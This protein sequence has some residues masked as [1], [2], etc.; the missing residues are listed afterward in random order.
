MDSV[1]GVTDHYPAVY[2]FWH[3]VPEPDEIR[4]QVRNMYE[5]GI[6]TFLIQARLAFP[7]EAYLGEGYFQAYRLAVQEAR[8]RGMKAG[9]YDEYNWCSGHAGGRT[10]ESNDQAREQHLFWSM[11]IIEGGTCTCRISGIHSLM[12]SGMGD[13]VM[14]WIYKDGKPEWDNWQIN[15]VLAYPQDGE[16]ILQSSIVDLTDNCSLIKTGSTGCQVKVDLPMSIT[17]ERYQI[18]A[19]LSGMCVSSRLINYLSAEAVDAFIKANYEPYRQ[20]LGE[21]FGDTIP[22]IFFDHPYSGFYDWQERTGNLGNSLMYDPELPDLFEKEHGYPIELALLS[23]LTKPDRQTPRLRADFFQTY[24]RLGRETFFGRIASWAKSNGLGLSGHELLPH[25]G[26]WGLTEGFKFLD[27]RTN[28]A[29]DYF[30]IDRYRTQT[31]VDACNLGPQISAKI[32]DSVAKANGRRGCLIEQYLVSRTEGVPGGAGC[33]GMT[34]DQLRSQAIR[35]YLFGASQFIFH[36]YYQ[37]DG[38]ASNQE[39]FK[40]PRFDFA[41]G[42]NFEPWFTKYPLFAEEMK[43]LAD[44][45]DESKSTPIVAVLYPMRTWWVEGSG[46]NFAVESSKWFQYLIEKNIQFDL[47]S[48]DQLEKARIEKGKLCIGDEGFETLVFPGVSTIKTKQILEKVKKFV[49]SGGKFIASGCLP[50]ASAEFGEEPDLRDAFEKMI[51]G[52]RRAEFYTEFPT[53]DKVINSFIRT[54]AYPEIIEG[55]TDDQIWSWWGEYGGDP[56]MLLFNDYKLDTR[57]GLK[58]SGQ[59]VEPYILDLSTRQARP[60]PW[61]ESSDQGM[62]IYRDLL[63]KQLGGLVLRPVDLENNHLVKANCRI[64]QIIRNHDGKT[65]LWA[66]LTYGNHAEL[67]IS[68]NDA[69]GMAEES[70]GVD[71]TCK[72]AGKNIWRVLLEDQ[73]SHAP[74]PL[75]GWRLSRLDKTEEILVDVEKG[76]ETQGWAD[77]AGEGTYH[78]SFDLSD[79]SK[80]LKYDLVLPRIETTAEVILNG[81]NIGTA[82]WN[83]YRFRLPAENLKRGENDLVVKVINTG[84]NHY[85]DQTSYEPAGKLPSGLIGRPFIERYHL[86]EIVF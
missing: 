67:I 68:S 86:I 61:Y 19:F 17:A 24:G 33:W 48:E 31:A 66:H 41:P 10:V 25:V 47:I 60:W 3:K 69:P 20:H 23:F 56:L 71:M 84:A 5:S 37:T 77:Y 38:T 52:S 79:F 4:T 28:F 44:L 11:G 85:Y 36:G 50:H 81:A 27:A 9:I 40:N 35:H 72:A 1:P 21:F 63:P 7:R 30:D 26:A 82:A 51:D 54:G 15:K 34:L 43:N 62:I 53:H 22:Y 57:I 58:V 55:S 64:E 80:R 49:T 12:F 18:T 78:C 32:G 46:H 65:R 73:R 74:Q 8:A 83:P 39:L 16:D 76:W 59:K 29:V 45:L 42:I 2:W 70:D 13:A 6:R 75:S 14:D